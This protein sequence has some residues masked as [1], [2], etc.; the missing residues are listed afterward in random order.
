MRFCETWMTH[1]RGSVP[2]SRNV[3]R[4]S[5]KFGASLVSG[6]TPHSEL[7]RQCG[8]FPASLTNQVFKQ[9]SAVWASG[10]CL[11]RLFSFLNVFSCWASR[12]A[13]W[14]M[15][16]FSFPEAPSGNV[17]YPLRINWRW[18]SIV[19]CWGLFQVMGA[20]VKDVVVR[21]D[22]AFSLSSS[23]NAKKRAAFCSHRDY[24]RHKNHD[25]EFL[26]T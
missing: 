3:S 21:F 16:S 13:I 7:T 17:W 9:Y 22:A 8:N 24:H 25:L 18:V 20:A 10:P 26:P 14:F 12:T 6:V 23:L 4:D 11:G 15:A 5:E 1:V 19:I 2:R